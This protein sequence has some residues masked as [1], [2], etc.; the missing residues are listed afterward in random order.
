MKTAFERSEPLA[1]QLIL[2]DELRVVVTSSA[3]KCHVRGIDFRAFVLWSQNLML[4]VAVGAHRNI[5]PALGEVLSMHAFEVVPENTRM[6]LTASVWHLFSGHRRREVRSACD[7]MRP[8]AG[9]T[10][11]AVGQTALAE[12]Q[13]V[14]TTQKVFHEGLTFLAAHLAE[15][16][17]ATGLGLIQRMGFGM[18]V[19]AFHNVVSS[20]ARHTAD[21][22][23][24]FARSGL[25]VHTGIE[26]L[27]C[28]V[29][30]RRAVDFG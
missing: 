4:T 11:G 28:F 1:R 13:T 25:E 12:S 27:L 3:R 8:V 23:G 9:R 29:M 30:T 14:R 5:A 2:L 15:V 18:S 20:M 7:G 6:T 16:A 22:I 17:L 10:R 19:A 26:L 21:C 24:R